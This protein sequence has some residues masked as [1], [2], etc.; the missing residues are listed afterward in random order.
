MSLTPRQIFDAIAPELAA[1]AAVDT[2][3][4]IALDRVDVA[5][6]T[7]SEQAIAYLAAHLMTLRDRASA[8][9]GSGGGASGALTFERAGQVSRQYA[10]TA[11][12]GVAASRFGAGGFQSTPYGVEYL[13]ILSQS[14]G[15]RGGS[16]ALR[17]AD[18]DAAQ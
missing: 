5:C 3:L 15:I 13:N 9:A 17:K 6:V 16:T 1:D 4:A 14:A 12:G 11:G 2:F 8:G 10:P 7:N 18:Y